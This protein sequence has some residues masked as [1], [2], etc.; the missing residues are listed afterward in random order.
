MKKW[1]VAT[2]EKTYVWKWN[3]KRNDIIIYYYIISLKS[4]IL[5]GKKG[6]NKFETSDK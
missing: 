6:L 2:F 5:Y 1:H 3:M 4:D